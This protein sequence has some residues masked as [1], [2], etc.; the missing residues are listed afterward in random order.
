MRWAISC[1]NPSLSLQLVKKAWLFASFVMQ[2]IASW[3]QAG[4][5]HCSW[6]RW[7]CS[8]STQRM[9]VFR[10]CNR[11][12]LPAGSNDAQPRISKV[13][14]SKIKSFFNTLIAQ[15]WSWRLDFV[16]NLT[17]EFA[18][19]LGNVLVIKLSFLF[20]FCVFGTLLLVSL[21]GKLLHLAGFC[22]I[23]HSE[24]LRG[25]WFWKSPPLAP[26]SP[27]PALKLEVLFRS[28]KGIRQQSKIWNLLNKIPQYNLVSKNLLNDIKVSSSHS[29]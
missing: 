12:L 21:S 22:K 24:W 15:P 23:H 13:I 6:Y 19:I 10:T 4:L 28:A 8:P 5:S 3:S 26:K 17:R 27:T 25:R 18:R 20:S 29:K 11:P 1:A 16:N 14:S 2:T 7:A 9:R